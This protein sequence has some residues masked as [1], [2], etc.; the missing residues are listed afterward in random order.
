[1]ELWNSG[2]LTLEQ[3]IPEAVCDMIKELLGDDRCVFVGDRYISFEDSTGYLLDLLNDLSALLMENG[4]SL[5]NGS[6]VQFYGDQE[7]YHV[8]TGS[9][10]ETMDPGEYAVY[11]LTDEE[12]CGIMT[13]RGYCVCKR[14][15]DTC[16]EE[17]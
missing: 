6:H 8:W 12:L 16:P 11:A 15:P 2:T 7:G 3:K 17:N 13:A 10:F 5:I 1:M 9:K 14:S 4:L